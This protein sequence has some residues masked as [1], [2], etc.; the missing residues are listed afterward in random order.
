MKTL[1]NV[2]GGAIIACAITAC[3]NVDEPETEELNS[4]DMTSLLTVKY[5]GETYTIPC[6]MKNDSLIYLDKKFNELYKNEIEKLPNRAAFCYKDEQG[7]D[8]IEYYSSSKELEKETKITYIGN[9]NTRMTRDAMPQPVAGRAILYDNKNYKDRTVI[10]DADLNIFP[11][12][13]NLKGYAG[14][15][16]KT[17]SIRVFNFL[18]PNKS[19]KPSYALPETPG[20]PGSQLRT[21]LIGYED[22]NFKGSVLYCIATYSN[23]ENLNDPSTA[24]HQ[25]YNLKKIGWNDKISSARFRIITVDNIN[26]GI[27]TPHKAL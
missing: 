13:P 24:T 27:Y 1:F 3:S 5:K 16:D 23:T 15:N 2:L 19:Y 7:N 25:D 17:S 21:C 4:N 22:S 10:M 8:V 18:N 6:I 20:T 26:K 11:N 12:I 9:N 14:F